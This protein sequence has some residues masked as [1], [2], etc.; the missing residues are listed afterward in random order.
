MGVEEII[1]VEKPEVSHL[2]IYERLVK[3]EE[4]VD[5]LDKKTSQVVAAF[6]A[7]SSAFIVLEWIGKVAKP[8][9]WLTGLGAVIATLYER[10]TK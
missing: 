7:A 10:W 1:G 6:D 2:Q 9:L 5:S 8:I 4:K 3:V